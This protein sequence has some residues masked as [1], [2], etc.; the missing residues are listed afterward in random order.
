MKKKVSVLLFIFI[1]SL[2]SVI[3]VAAAEKDGF[4]DEYYRVSD[5]ADLL[6][7]NEEELL[8][9][10]LD[11]ISNRQKLDIV[12]VTALNTENYS[13]VDYAEKL[14]EDCKFGYG[15][16]KDGILLLISM[17]QRDWQ[18]VT[19]G[20]G[21][22]AFTNEGINYIGDKITPYMSDGEW[23]KAFNE[24][25]EL[26]DLFVTQAR[27]DTPYD[28]GNLPDEPLSLIWIPISIAVGLIIALIIVGNMKGELKTVRAKNTA[29]SYVKNGSMNITDQREMFLYNTVTKVAKQS[30]SNN[31]TSGGS[32]THKSSSGSTFGGGNGKF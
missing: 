17:E 31:S 26:C 13:I 22:T 10:K 29:N 1:L 28:K 6:S 12:I 5:M 8:I 7:E 4:A 14:Y 24:Y 2:L 30:N 9:E 15:E 19:H 27:S 16:A 23:Y 11:E 25:S 3:P 18:I 21:I 32:N 20:Y